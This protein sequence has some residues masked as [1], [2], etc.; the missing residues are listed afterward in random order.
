MRTDLLSTWLCAAC[1]VVACLT[2]AA[3]GDAD[4]AEAAT[5]VGDARPVSRA[6]AQPG[7]PATSATPA[8]APRALPIAQHMGWAA[9]DSHREDVDPSHAAIA[10]Y[11]D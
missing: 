11:G 1:G 5:R 8:M 2:L 6:V 3:C 4:V 7:A 10:S 9:L